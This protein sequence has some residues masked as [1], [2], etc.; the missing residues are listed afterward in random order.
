MFFNKFNYKKIP[1]RN[2]KSLKLM[3]Q[4]NLIKN[5]F[6]QNKFILFYY[7]NIISIDAQKNLENILIAENLKYY[8]I[9]GN[10]L[11]KILLDSNLNN[12]IKNNV[13]IIFNPT[14]KES[15]FNYTQFTKK[16]NFKSIH[17]FGI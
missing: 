1:Y 9:K 10:I 11:N 5:C 17:F 2:Y 12:L 15:N 16:L 13:L 4:S 3:Y 14:L 8:K 7:Y 6:L